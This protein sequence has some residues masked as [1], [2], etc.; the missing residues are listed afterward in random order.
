MAQHLNFEVQMLFDRT[1]H[2]IAYM[3]YELR[4][5]IWWSLLTTFFLNH[6]PCEIEFSLA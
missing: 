2:T 6:V 5:H 3:L 4:T 1:C